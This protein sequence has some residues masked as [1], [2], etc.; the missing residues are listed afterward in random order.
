MN[1]SILGL[2]GVAIDWVTISAVS[3]ALLSLIKPFLETIPG[4]RPND[5][6]HDA[7]IRLASV[8]LNLLVALAL[9]VA[10]G[11]LTARDIGQIVPALIL[12][13]L[14]GAAGA[15][16]VYH[17]ITRS[18]KSI[19]SPAPDV[20]ALSTAPAVAQIGKTS[21]LATNDGPLPVTSINVP[22]SFNA[23]SSVAGSFTRMA[24]ADALNMPHTATAPVGALSQ[25]AGAI[26]ST[27]V[28]LG[29]LGGPRNDVK[30]PQ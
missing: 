11:T 24:P 23:A 10:N 26:L 6:N 14:G 3:A 29:A 1:T 18:G 4:G 30:Q 7:T 20:T 2:P 19:N 17:T 9:L 22:P 21:Y 28:N 15:H 16:L 27:P 12:Y 13:A 5:P 25:G 8:A